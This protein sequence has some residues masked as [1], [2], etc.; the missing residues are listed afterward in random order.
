[1]DRQD[2][3]QRKL[4]LSSKWNALL[5]RI[6]L[7]IYMGTHHPARLD[8]IRLL[9]SIADTEALQPLI[10]VE[11]EC[12]L[13]AL[14]DGGISPFAIPSTLLAEPAM[15]PKC[16]NTKTDASDLNQFVLFMAT[17]KLISCVSQLT[18]RQEHGRQSTGNPTDSSDKTLGL[19]TTCHLVRP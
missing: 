12:Q 16:T 1:M 14:D 19:S 15:H 5:A 9:V 17:L 3:D 4:D 11:D 10:D 13:V 18:K 6:Y 8:K 7:D 2:Q